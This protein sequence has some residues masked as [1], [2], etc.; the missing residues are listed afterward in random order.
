MTNETAIIISSL[1]GG[2]CFLLFFISCL[3]LLV[4][5]IWICCK[6]DQRNN[7]DTELQYHPVQSQYSN[8]L[9]TYLANPLNNPA[10]T[11]QPPPYESLHYPNNYMTQTYIQPN[12]TQYPTYV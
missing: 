11:N 2:L 5:C 9:V 3:F 7:N 1:L 4:R 10:E 12:Y 8:E 6:C